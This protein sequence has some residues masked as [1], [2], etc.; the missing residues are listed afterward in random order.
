MIPSVSNNYFFDHGFVLLLNAGFLSVHSIEKKKKE[1]PIVINSHRVVAPK[2]W[3]DIESY[4]RKIAFTG[5][6]SKLNKFPWFFHSKIK[7]K[8]G[9]QQSKD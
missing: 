4:H 1:P 2:W 7:F 8:L 3:L 6:R 5:R 9:L